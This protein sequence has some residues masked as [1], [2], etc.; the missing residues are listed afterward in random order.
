MR[1]REFT[2]EQVEFIRTGLQTMSTRKVAEAY[3]RHFG[4][5][6]GQTQLRRACDRN[7]ISNPRGEN[8]PLPT[9]HERWS[10]FYQCYV[11]KVRQISVKGMKPSRE[12]ERLRASQWQLKQVYVWENANGCKLPD[13][14]VIVF[15]DGDRTNYDPKNLYAS[16]LE[17][18]GYV[19]RTKIDSEFPPVMKSALMCSELAFAL[20]RQRKGER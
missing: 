4:E 12:R 20:S 2:D 10:D 8:E 1:K 9:G 6:L 5:P 18:V 3:S 14:W 19:Y 7:G 11:V 16:P 15:L 17:E 13:G